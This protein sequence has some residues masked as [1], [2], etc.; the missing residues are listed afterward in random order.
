MIRVTYRTKLS[1][2]MYFS[3]YHIIR[4]RGLIIFMYLVSCLIA[5]Q[6]LPEDVEIVVGV[7]AFVIMSIIIFSVF[8]VLTFPLAFI[9]TQISGK[10]KTLMTENSIELHEEHFVSENQY[11]RSVL[12]WDIV[13]KLRRTK[14]FIFVYVSKSSAVIIPKKAFL[15]ED[16]WNSFYHF[17]QTH[18]NVKA[19]G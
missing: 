5:Y 1:H 14:R 19:T 12:K 9:L 3:W 17:L 7:I 11:G 13:Q 8:L 16:D 2:L 15:S 10:N 18:C 6:S 4:V